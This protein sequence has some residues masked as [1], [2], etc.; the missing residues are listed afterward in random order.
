MRAGQMPFLG[1]VLI[2]SLEPKNMLSC[3][4]WIGTVPSVVGVLSGVVQ[5][6]ST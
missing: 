4:N 2:V 3:V 5:V 6:V 1:Q